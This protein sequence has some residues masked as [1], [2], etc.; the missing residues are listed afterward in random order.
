MNNRPLLT[1]CIP[2]YNRA[3]LLAPLLESTLTQSFNDYEVLI[4]ED[5][6]PERAAIGDVAR[7]FQQSYPGRIRYEENPVNLGY[8]GNIR[9]LVER[10]QG[11]Y[12]VFM[13]NDDL[14]CDGAL[15]RIADAVRAQPD[16]GVVVRSYASFEAD[17]VQPK[18]VFR[19]YPLEHVL[20]AGAQAVFTA[21][22]RSVVISGMVV[23]RDAAQTVATAR[24]DGTLLY[25]LYLVGMILATHGVVFV[26]EII[27]LRRNGTPPDFGNSDAERGKF[28]PRDQ[29]PESSLHFMRGML[30][31]AQHVEEVTRLK[32]YKT[33]RSDIGNYAYPILSI[34]AKR[35]LL[36][37]V[38][39]GLSLAGLGLWRYPLFHLY[40]IT[41][42][43][44][45][46]DRTDRIINL[47][48]RRLG[49]TP[50][51]GAA[52]GGRQ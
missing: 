14:L 31:I 44:I 11:H 13:G 46:P 29:T 3:A 4:C 48:K 34:Q 2:A 52:R 38:R 16:C 7:R 8:D 15:R 49:Y 30:A 23:H 6:S 19:Y 27:A 43:M 18:Q 33:I 24:F 42:L 26:P 20:P 17:P 41:L 32:V 45:G 22:R 28:V 1:V 12:C 21:Y 25:Q 51:L 10:A 50:R 35:S 5:G 36:V 9:R 47:I 40:F 37:F 39:Y